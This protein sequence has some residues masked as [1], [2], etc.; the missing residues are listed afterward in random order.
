MRCIRCGHE[1]SQNTCTVCGLSMEHDDIISVA[2]LSFS[3]NVESSIEPENI[4]EPV[5]DPD[6]LMSDWERGDERACY[7]LGYIYM[8]G[9]HT[10]VNY[11]EAIKWFTKLAEKDVEPAA[12][13]GFSYESPY[14]YFSPNNNVLRIDARYQ[15]G[16]VFDGKIDPMKKLST[17]FDPG[18][19]KTPKDNSKPHVDSD[20]ALKWYQSAAENGHVLAL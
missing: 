13:S 5:F 2:S 19:R 1:T 6:S 7:R 12:P 10:K 16:R 4:T 8:T 20:I 17:G 11:E 14:A 3:L 18:S 15:L 9:T